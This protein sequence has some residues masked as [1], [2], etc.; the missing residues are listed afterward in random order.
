MKYLNEYL[1]KLFEESLRINSNDHVEQSLKEKIYEELLISILKSSATVFKL[2]SFVA[3]KLISNNSLRTLKE[4]G[5]MENLDK[6]ISISSDEK[7][8]NRRDNLAWY[9]FKAIPNA[10]SFEISLNSYD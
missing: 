2:A 8:S 9:P 1:N 5:L 7:S 3:N 4:L 6:D 10:K